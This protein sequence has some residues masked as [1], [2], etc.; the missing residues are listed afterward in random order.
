[1]KSQWFL[2]LALIFA[3]IT[4]TFAVINVEQVEVNFLFTSVKLPLILLILGSVL[5]GGLIVG[6]FGIYRGFRQQRQIKQLNAKLARI[7]EVTGYDEMDAASG[8]SPENGFSVN[9]SAGSDS[10]LNE[11]SAH[12]FSAAKASVPSKDTE[13][14]RHAF[15]EEKDVKEKL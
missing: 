14:A 12:P 8:G 3:L 15:S 2:I 4:A 7:L 6:A 1:M 5:L 13:T 9:A 11:S 10:S